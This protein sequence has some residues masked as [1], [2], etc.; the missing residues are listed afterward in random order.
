MSI[1]EKWFGGS[2][3]DIKKIKVQPA[4]SEEGWG[5]EGLAE[6]RTEEDKDLERIEFLG[7]SIIQRRAESNLQEKMMQARQV[8]EERKQLD[9]E[10]G[11]KHGAAIMAQIILIIGE[12]LI[13]NKQISK[14]EIYPLVTEKFSDSNL[15]KQAFGQA[16]D[17]VKR[18]VAEGSWA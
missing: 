12:E 4:E 6:Q 9:P 7:Q 5:E 13:R 10:N 15:I 2:D 14:G 3:E 11:E 1:F 16:W 8:I 18:Y 17:K